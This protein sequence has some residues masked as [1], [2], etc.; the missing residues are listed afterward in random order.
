MVNDSALIEMPL[1]MQTV[2]QN[3]EPYSHWHDKA[4]VE[5]NKN[6]SRF[7]DFNSLQR[8]NKIPFGNARLL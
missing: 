5:A 4:L 1:Q 8:F 2:S 3:L 7:A 6:D